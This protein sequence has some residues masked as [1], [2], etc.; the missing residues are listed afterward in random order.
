MCQCAETEMIMTRAS[1]FPRKI[2]L[3]SVSQLSK[4]RGS[5]RQNCLNSAARHGLP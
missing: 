4:F 3:N 5:P 2:F 1:S